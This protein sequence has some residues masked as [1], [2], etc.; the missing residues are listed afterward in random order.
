MPMRI[1]TYTSAFLDATRL[2]EAQITHVQISVNMTSE[3]MAT[4]AMRDSPKTCVDARETRLNTI[5]TE[6]ARSRCTYELGHVSG[7]PHGQ[8]VIV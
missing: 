1:A 5:G 3:T 8:H 6:K 7:L 4:T 2:A